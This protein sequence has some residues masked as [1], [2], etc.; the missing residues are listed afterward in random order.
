M[1]CNTTIVKVRYAAHQLQMYPSWL[2]LLPPK[3]HQNHQ[4]PWPIHPYRTLRIVWIVSTYKVQSWKFRSIMKTFQWPISSIIF[5]SLAFSAC[6]S[7]FSS[8]SLSFSDSRKPARIIIW[9][10]LARLASRERLAATL[11]LF[12][13][14]QYFSSLFSSGTNC[15]KIRDEKTSIYTSALDHST[16]AVPYPDALT[17]TWHIQPKL[18]PILIFQPYTQQ[19][20]YILQS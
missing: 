17:K 13:L 6:N 10:S 7:S 3:Y 12:L 15:Y 16:S 20:N 18:T 19:T 5:R 14:F 8:V 2:Y 9:F 11:F 4:I 1:K